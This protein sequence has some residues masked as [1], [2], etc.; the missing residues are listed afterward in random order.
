[1][2][3][4]IKQ[5]AGSGGPMGGFRKFLFRGNLVDLAV[6]VVIGTGFAAL[7]QALVR[8]IFTPLIAAAGGKP[9]FGSLYFTVNHSRFAYGDFINAIVAFL[10]IA[11]VVY[12]IVV[13]P[14][15]RLTAL[16]E[17]RK[18]ATERTCPECLS[19]IPVAARRCKFCTAEVPPAR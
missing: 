9:N 7:V 11:L 8:D 6:A 2:R 13:A 5:N 12:F 14:V 18:E 15:A 10:V 17:R 1:M 19:D 4:A 16:A 3:A